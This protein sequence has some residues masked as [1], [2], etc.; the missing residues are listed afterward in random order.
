MPVVKWDGTPPFGGKTLVLPGG[1]Y[2]RR[3]SPP[4]QSVSAEPDASERQ[5]HRDAPDDGLD[6]SD[7]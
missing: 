2:E 6:L 3:R 4:A 7:E 1:A 5:P